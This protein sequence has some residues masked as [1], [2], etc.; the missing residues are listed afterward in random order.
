MPEAT[1]NNGKPRIL[2]SRMSAIGDTILTMPVACALRSEFPEAHL[3]WVVE[4]KAAP[5]IR[6][7]PV[8]DEVVELERGWFTSL[9]GMRETRLKLQA[10]E[11]EIAIDCQGLTKSA[12]A[13]WL[14]GAKRRIG[15]SGRHGGELTQWLN[16]E[17]IEPTAS[18]IVDRSLELLQ[19]LGIH[20]PK[21]DWQMP[22]PAEATDWANGWRQK[23]ASE[24]I[25][26]LN[27]GCTAES[28]MWEPDRFGQTAEIIHKRYGYRSV[29]VWGG[30]KE[31][32]MAE[33]IV[34]H[35]KG[36]AVL[37]PDTSLHQLAAM[38]SKSDLFVS[39]DTGPLHMAVALDVPT[40]GLYGATK[41]GDSGP[42][43][44]IALQNAYEAGSR[45]HRRKADNTAMRQIHVSDVCH[46]IDRLHKNFP[47][48]PVTSRAA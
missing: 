31:R 7:H 33:W 29:A 25:A 24:R 19:P 21:V 39:G 22:I 2:L 10:F 44:Q 8:V 16:N 36:T 11:P 47:V 35:S 13:G 9:R 27:P 1:L 6:N 26:I 15:Y 43:Q 17:L 46:A 20:S 30:A 3:V 40:I 23:I 34:R 4:R 18:H 45:R 38:I 37:A 41:P 42:Y 32:A 14:S 48:S 12:L 28:R 5:M